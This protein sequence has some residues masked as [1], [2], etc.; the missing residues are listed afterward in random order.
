MISSLPLVVRAVAVPGLLLAAAPAVATGQAATELLVNA[1]WLAEHLRDP[2]LVLLHVGEKPEYDA[3]HIPGARFIRMQDL[4]LPRVEGELTLEL[5]SP[6]AIRAQLEQFGISDDSRVVVYYGND[7]VTPSTRVL[8]ALYYAG[9]GDRT[10]LLNGGMPAWLRA[11]H[12]V[13]AE[14]P[15]VARGRLSARAARRDVIADAEFVRGTAQRTGHVLVDARPPVYWD[16]TEPK[17]GDTPAGHIPGA[18][19]VPYT[20]LVDDALHVDLPGIERAFRAAGIMPGDTVVGYCFIGQYA[21]ASLFAARLLGHP[22]KLYDGS[23]DDWNRR[24][25]PVEKAA[26]R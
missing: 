7:W 2:N 3:S 22:V 13:T 25:L 18:R 15:A 20:T 9:L 10:S 12:A 16:G 6:D 17:D 4:S 14:Q 21:T 23:M 24:G 5:A 1:D 11:G 19:N 26:Q 8:Y